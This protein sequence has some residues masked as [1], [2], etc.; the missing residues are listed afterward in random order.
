MFMMR[1]KVQI[2]RVAKG[3]A[4]VRAAGMICWFVP[5]I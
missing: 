3:A 1:T 4:F 5:F 2:Q